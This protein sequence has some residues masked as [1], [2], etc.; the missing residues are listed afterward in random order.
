MSKRPLLFSLL[1]TPI[2]LVAPPAALAYVGPGLG[3]SAI[4]SLLALLAAIFVAIFG[5]LWYPIKRVLRRLRGRDADA[6]AGQA[7][8]HDGPDE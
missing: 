3:L 4:G 1:A 2:L 8:H 6:P 5:F 7:A